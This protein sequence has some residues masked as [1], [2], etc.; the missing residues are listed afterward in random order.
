MFF[1]SFLLISRSLLKGIS[2][3]TFTMGV[4][5]GKHLKVRQRQQKNKKNK[6]TANSEW[7]GTSY[8]SWGITNAL[9]NK[10][11]TFCTQ[12]DESSF[13]S[14]LSLLQ[15]HSIC[16]IRVTTDLIKIH[17]YG[18]YHTINQVKL[19]INVL[20]IKIYSSAHKL[21]IKQSFMM[22]PKKTAI[23]AT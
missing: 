20:H 8:I 7:N 12:N 10:F 21:I 23:N 16:W 9:C 19:E 15:F 1:L 2:N 18:L 5:L 4:W 17:T 22:V 6:N 13:E 14:N 3:N 11:N